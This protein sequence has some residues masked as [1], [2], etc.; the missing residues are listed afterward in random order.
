MFADSE[1]PRGLTRRSMLGGVVGAGL[2][3]V[4]ASGA[5]ADRE[6]MA[7]TLPAGT[8]AILP[9]G[10]A[11]PRPRIYTRRE[12]KATPP[13][14]PAT[15][16]DRAPTRIIVHHT[17][18]PNS[19]DETLAHAFRISRE[20]QELHMDSNGWDDIGQQFTISRGGFVMEGRNRSLRAVRDGRLAVGAQV[21]H[22]NGHTIGIENEGTYMKAAV[23]GRLWSSLVEVCAWLCEAYGLDPA[24]A[25]VGHRD[26][27]DT[28]CP[29]DV[30]YARLPE[31]RDAVAARLN[32]SPPPAQADGGPP[33][34]GG[35]VPEHDQGAEHSPSP[36]HHPDTEPGTGDGPAP[37]AS[38]LDH[39]HPSGQEFSEPTRRP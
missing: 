14:H 35:P 4:L 30:L 28:D 10:T 20:I 2:L 7:A 11:A 31:L 23:P 17:E 16:L 38:H 19:A 22:H 39:G 33:E 1:G 12:W 26:Y 13:R 8:A 29:G 15:V 18:W 24:R 3:E 9:P 21:L 32:G 6:A 36:G 37:R 34:D 5:S 25:I 27:N